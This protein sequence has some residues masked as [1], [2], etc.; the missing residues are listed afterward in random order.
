[1][2]TAAGNTSSTATARATTPC[3]TTVRD[4]L[5]RGHGRHEYLPND[6]GYHDQILNAPWP[7]RAAPPSALPS[8]RVGDTERLG[9]ILWRYCVS[10]N[11]VADVA[12]LPLKSQQPLLM[13][14]TSTSALWLDQEP[15]HQCAL[16]PQESRRNTTELLKNCVALASGSAMSSKP[17][18]PDAQQ[19]PSLTSPSSPASPPLS[20]SPGN[21]TRRR[22]GDGN[23]N[24]PAS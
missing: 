11:R 7:Q 3:T 13:Q 4:H 22:H 10:I 12:S 19:D 16:S 2:T 15:R 9:D 6:H 1:M 21:V 20:Q 17:L 18:A 14:R 24:S 8:L 5:P 23:D